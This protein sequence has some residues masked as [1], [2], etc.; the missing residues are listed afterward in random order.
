MTEL[1]GFV[2]NE[3]HYMDGCLIYI[4]IS[5]IVRVSWNDWLKN[6]GMMRK[7]TSFQVYA[8]MHYRMSLRDV[9]EF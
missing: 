3:F 7:T 9:E 5:S 8:C 2:L 1:I 6:Y 4:I